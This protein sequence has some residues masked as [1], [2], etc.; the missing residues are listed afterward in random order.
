MMIGT[1]PRTLWQNAVNSVAGAERFLRERGRAPR[2]PGAAAGL[3]A[4]AGRSGGRW[5]P[6]MRVRHSKFGLGTVLECEGEGEDTKLTVSFPGYGRIK[7]VE[8]YAALEK[9]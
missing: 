5:R 9:A 1:K 4:A 6:G 7:L 8:R 2:K 3:K